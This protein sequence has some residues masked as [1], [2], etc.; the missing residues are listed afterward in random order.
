[1]SVATVGLTT[2]TADRRRRAGQRLMI[3]LGG[4][5][6][7]GEERALIREIQPC[8]FILF[9]RNV[10][11][12]AQLRELNR[13][14]R[15]LVD[16]RFPALCAVDQEGGRVQ[17]IREP[18][19]VW[20]PMRWLGNASRP[21]LTTDVAA[22]MA[23]ELRAMEFDLDFAPVADVNS[24][25]QNPVI[26][27]R[28]FGSTAETVCAQVSAFIP[29]MHAE[30]IIACAKHFPGHGDT[31]VD[32]DLDLPTVEEDPDKLMEREVA[33][34]VAAIAAGVGM[35]MTAHVIY[36][37]WDE[38]NP[39]TMSERILR[40]LLRQRLGFGGVIVSDDLEM[41]AVRGRFPLEMQLQ[42]ASNATVDLFL[43]CKTPELQHEAYELLIR[44]QEEDRRQDDLAVDAVRRIHTLRERFLRDRPPA[45][46][47]EVLGLAA[48]RDRAMQMRVE[49][50]E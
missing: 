48:H 16:P 46:G 29:A 21:T 47:L 5:S 25:P 42:R 40:G 26:G 3:G 23:R 15:S 6:I 17:R 12:P 8:G 44:L 2:T 30:G 32:S 43:A 18:A 14:L 10:E 22:A 37:A 38:Q 34:F 49:G 33:P 45:L 9:A 31:R 39:A 1:M 13:E 19:T 24:N 36:P 20:P 11:E 50:A 35:V 27:D 7:S 28:A 4:P 41:K